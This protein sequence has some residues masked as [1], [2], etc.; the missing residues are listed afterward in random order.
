MAIGK[1]IVGSELENT[2]ESLDFIQYKSNI[3]ACSVG[4]NLANL[5]RS[6]C[7][8]LFWQKCDLKKIPLT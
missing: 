2:L 6:E 7:F 8:W 4:F 5:V 3:E 1:C